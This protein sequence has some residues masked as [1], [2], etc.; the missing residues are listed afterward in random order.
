MGFQA[1]EFRRFHNYS[2]MIVSDF[3]NAFCRPRPVQN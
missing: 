3:R 2:E 1:E